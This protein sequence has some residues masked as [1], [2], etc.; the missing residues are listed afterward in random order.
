MGRANVAAVYLVHGT[1]CGND[2]LGLLTELARYAPRGSESLRRFTKGAFDLLLGE[3]GNYTAAFAARMESALSTGAG[4][5]IPVRRFHWSSQNHHIGRADGA[6]RLIDELADFAATISP[7][8]PLPPVGRAGEGGGAGTRRDTPPP[9]PP[10]QG[11]GSGSRGVPPRVLLWGHSHGGNI[12]ALASNLLGS[13]GATRR[14][15][16][17]A[18]RSFYQ[19]WRSARIDFPVWQRVEDLLT[20]TTHPLRR[21]ALDMVTFGTPIRYGWESAGYSRLLH[22]VG[23]RPHDPERHWLAP[24]P[25]RLHGVLTALHGD[26]VHHLGIAGSGFP[27]FPLAFRTLA[28]NRRM[29]RILARHVPGWLLTR[30]RAGS[31][32]HHDGATMLVDY[33]DPVR[34]PLLHIFGHALYTRSHWL[35][36]HCELVAKEFYGHAT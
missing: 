29:R 18:A 8:G 36:L 28:A 24:Y 32:V 3:A 15:F 22:F 27:P 17:H 11:E 14:E 21:V 16:F 10:H 33:A 23:H 19:R 4:R 25:P 9:T 6:V 30:M 5:T 7:S 1:F 34:F 20:S 35:P 12:F 13:D 31:R 26:F 2:P